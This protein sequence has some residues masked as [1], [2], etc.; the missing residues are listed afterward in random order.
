MAH[1]LVPERGPVLVEVRYRIDRARSAEFAEAMREVRRIRLR[2][3]AM[4]WGLFVDSADPTLHTEVFL[5]KSWIEHLRQH[6]RV[7][8]ADRDVEVQARA[9]HVGPEP[10][11]VVHL[12]AESV[13]RT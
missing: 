4:Q 3:G 10:P 11:E 6:E 9:F 7:T 12:I 1:D 2:D 8:H 5:V 13:L